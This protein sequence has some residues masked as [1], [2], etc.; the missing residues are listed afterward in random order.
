[1]RRAA[2]PDGA[3]PARHARLVTTVFMIHLDVAERLSVPTDVDAPLGV[4]AR[5]S[6]AD[7]VAR[8]W[9]SR[10]LS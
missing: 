4:S 1:M 10:R 5:V 6:G 2:D 8:S 7:V 3:G 9:L